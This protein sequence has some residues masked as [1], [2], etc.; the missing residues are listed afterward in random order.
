MF[1]KNRQDGFTLL[2]VMISLIILGIGILGL[3]PLIGMAIYGNSYSNDA[4]AASVLAQREVEA[5]LNKADYGVL[6]YI[7]TSDSVNGLYSVSRNVVDNSTNAAVPPGL[8]RISVAVSWT[9]M[10]K[11]DRSVNFST[12]KP[13]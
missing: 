8:V 2:E 4:T 12:L 3:A 13:Q 7:S 10:Q 5:L 11:T 6:P 9:D 1:S